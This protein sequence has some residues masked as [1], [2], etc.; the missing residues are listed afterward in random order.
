[1]HFL[2]LLLI[3]EGITFCKVRSSFSGRACGVLFSLLDAKKTL[4]VGMQTL[5]LGIFLTD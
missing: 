5:V 1:M 2:S 3:S 4:A